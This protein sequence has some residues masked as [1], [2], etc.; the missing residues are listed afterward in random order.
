MIL[1]ALF[2][3]VHIH[4][5]NVGLECTAHT[6]I[7]TD[8]HPNAPKPVTVCQAYPASP[9]APLYPQPAA[10][11]PKPVLSQRSPTFLHLKMVYFV[12]FGFLAFL[13]G[14]LGIISAGGGVTISVMLLKGIKNI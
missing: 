8:T 9:G 7:F 2:I 5:V 14:F 13:Y 1:L 12:P 3:D 11:C 4:T 6:L 10:L